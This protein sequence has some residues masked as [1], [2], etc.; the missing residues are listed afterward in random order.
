[1][2]YEVIHEDG[3]ESNEFDFYLAPGAIF[4]RDDVEPDLLTHLQIYG[5]CVPMSD[6][7]DQGEDDDDQG[8]DE[9]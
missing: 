9:Q 2:D 4:R 8:E 5:Y 6:E 3:I 7:D 1:M